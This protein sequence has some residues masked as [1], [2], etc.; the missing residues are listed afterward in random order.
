MEKKS[1]LIPIILIV[2]FVIILVDTAFFGLFILYQQNKNK[3][4]D[5]TIAAQKE[6]ILTNMQLIMKYKQQIDQTTSK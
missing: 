5:A 3:E 6:V 4:L 1:R 2:L